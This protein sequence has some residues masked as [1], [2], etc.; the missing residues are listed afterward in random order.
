[1]GNLANA[2]K[3][4]ASAAC[5]LIFDA[6]TVLMKKIDASLTD[7]LARLVTIVE[8]LSH[9]LSRAAGAENE[10][11][12][13]SLLKSAVAIFNHLKRG[14]VSSQEWVVFYGVL[15][16]VLNLVLENPTSQEILQDVVTFLQ[17][18][19]PF[20]PKGLYQT[21]ILDFNTAVTVR[22]ET[23]LAEVLRQVL[24][25]DSLEEKFVTAFKSCLE[26]VSDD[27]RRNT[28][29][30]DCARLT[31]TRIMDI[32]N[33]LL[34]TLLQEDATVFEKID[35]VATVRHLN[36]DELADFITT[37]ILQKS[38]AIEKKFV[39]L[40]RLGSVNRRKH[41]FKSFSNFLID[42]SK[43][44]KYDNP[45]LVKYVES[46]TLESKFTAKKYDTKD[47][48][49]ARDDIKEQFKST[50]KTDMLKPL[51]LS[52]EYCKSL[53]EARTK[54]TETERPFNVLES[55]SI[56]SYLLKMGLKALPEVSK[57]GLL[58]VGATGSGKS[59]TT[60]FLCGCEMVEDEETG[61]VDVAASSK[62]VTDIGHGTISA[63]L[64]PQ[65]I[66]RPDINWLIADLPGL[67]DTRGFE[68]SIANVVNIRRFLKHCSSVRILL[69]IEYSSIASRSGV[70]A[71]A[72]SSVRMLQEMLKDKLK[73]SMTSILVGLT[74]I[75]NVK[76]IFIKRKVKDF[77]EHIH[78]PYN[79]KYFVVID[80]LAKTPETRLSVLKSAINDLSPLTNCSELF[81]A[82]ID[83]SDQHN[84]RKIAEALTDI[85][86]F[87]HKAMYEEVIAR[88]DLL[89]SLNTIE[90]PITQSFLDEFRSVVANEF[91]LRCNAIL[92]NVED[93][94]DIRKRLEVK[95]LL[96][97][98]DSA[99]ML[100]QC[101][102][103]GDKKIALRVSEVLRLY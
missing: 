67:L 75:S 76:P 40:S 7:R 65:T 52:D 31:R 35:D 59:T 32:N 56:I 9:A 54:S 95:K 46:F 28:D 14:V 57:D 73:S 96:E 79:D 89:Y 2:A 43:T 4:D 11:G 38:P 1:M 37:E 72:G 80:P 21:A 49:A 5:T 101:F 25:C 51:D 41:F 82:A 70:E 83:D 63:T 6:A 29:Y 81:H 68:F 91:E 74:K 93:T 33:E 102:E 42:L 3:G 18:T 15:E 45:V 55:I 36:D 71:V 97:L 23:K 10:F 16:F 8:G 19:C 87:M 53:I 61:N 90:H 50:E 94:Q 22:I 64:I 92:I 78:W 77:Y 17:S 60:N 88:Y 85:K 69:L 66:S 12:K 44:K 84:I 34:T 58:M 30:V 62:S 13:Q 48:E 103:E 100:D 24:F 39:E 99:G 86:D 47:I 26:A 20:L 27:V 98:I